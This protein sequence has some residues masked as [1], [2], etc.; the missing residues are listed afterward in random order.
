[1]SAAGTP[2]ELRAGGSAIPS[3]AFPE[4]AARALG[5]AAEYGGWRERAEGRVP[6]LP[7]VRRDEAAALLAAALVDP[8]A[9]AWLPPD[10]VAA[11]LDCYGIAMAPAE[12]G[13]VELVVGVVHDPSFGSVVACGAGGVAAEL[14][15]DVAI[16]LTPLTDRDAAEM[17]RSLASFPLLDGSAAPPRPTWPPWR[18]CCCGSAPWPRRT[19]RWPSST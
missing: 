11:L 10:R 1:M 19:R 4:D 16:G 18:T 12:A 7:G 5:R 3:Y 14:L 9:P 8:P 15:K 17:V 2:P 6:D 13:G